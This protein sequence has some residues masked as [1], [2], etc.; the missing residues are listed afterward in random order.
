MGQK[1]ILD[2]TTIK[3]KLQVK[4]PQYLKEKDFTQLKPAAVLIPLVIKQGK[5]CV[6]FTKRTEQLNN[7]RNQ[8]SFPGGTIEKKD[9]DALQAALRETEEE[10]GIKKE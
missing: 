4:T 6:L 9:H 1:A 2:I 8:I 3:H 7:H 5:L 10:I